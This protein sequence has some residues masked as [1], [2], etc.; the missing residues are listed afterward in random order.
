[1]TPVIPPQPPAQGRPGAAEVE[2][3]QA[4][5]FRRLPREALERLRPLLRARMLPGHRVAFREGQPA[6]YLWVLRRGQVR[7]TK[8]SPN[9]RTMTLELDTGTIAVGPSLASQLFVERV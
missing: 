1:M 5:L 7:L 9:G 2:L 6:E 3:E 8:S 4:E